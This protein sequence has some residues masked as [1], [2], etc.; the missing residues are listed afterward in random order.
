MKRIFFL[1]LIFL[2]LLL[3]AQNKE[4]MKNMLGIE[5]YVEDYITHKPISGVMV[6]VLSTDSITLQKVK[7]GG[8][9]VVNGVRTTLSRYRLGLER[10]KNY[11]L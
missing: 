4:E 6:E 5:G 11:I 8:M 10:G 3:F 1:I 2:P 9:K 7:A